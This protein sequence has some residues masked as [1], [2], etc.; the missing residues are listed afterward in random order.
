[1]VLI[2]PRMRASFNLLLLV[3]SWNCRRGS[4][5]RQNGRGVRYANRQLVMAKKHKVHQIW[6][7]SSHIR[8]L[9]SWS[10]FLFVLISSDPSET[11]TVGDV[12][13]EEFYF[14][15]CFNLVEISRVQSL[16]ERKLN[17]N[18]CRWCGVPL[19]AAAAEGMPIL[20]APACLVLPAENTLW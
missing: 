9:M 20:T 5:R 15:A 1:M 10:R 19:A 13:M 6:T 7:I 8:T 11:T 18:H 14:C 16:H 3:W 2:N 4:E 12:E 17:Q